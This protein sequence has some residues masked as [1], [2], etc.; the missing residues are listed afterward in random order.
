MSR[1]HNPEN[2]R[3]GGRTS[4]AI[5]VLVVVVVFGAASGGSTAEAGSV[6][7]VDGQRMESWELDRELAIVISRGSYHRQVSEERLEELRCESLRGLVLK[8]LKLRWVRDNPVSIDPATEEA[9]W[10]EVRDRFE[11]EKQYRTALEIKGIEEEALRRAIRRDLV[12]EA[13]DESVLAAVTPPGDTEVE[14]YFILHRDD[15]MTPEARHVVHVLVHVPPSSSGEEWQQAEQR[16]R[17]LARRAAEGEGSL[18]TVA[19]SEMAG[20][21]PSFRD[22][23]GDI[24]YVHR[25]SLQPA[26]DEAVFAAEPGSVTDPVRTL[27][28]YHVLQVISTRPPQPIDL[29]DV[30]GAVEERVTRERGQIRLDGFEQEL[31]DGAVIEVSEC[32]GSF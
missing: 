8:E 4:V 5:G 13:V 7:S 20:L 31:M 15:Y 29:A 11:S 19:E 24:G 21:P 17:E 10:L 3:F 22:Q 2:V 14:V 12:A 27:Y 30:R 9:A 23:V 32:H 25:G 16:A 1:A 28:G 26:V 18:F 6:A